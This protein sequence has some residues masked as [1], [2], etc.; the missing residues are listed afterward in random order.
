MNKPIGPSW[1]GIALLLCAALAHGQ[2]GSYDWSG[3]SVLGPGVKHATI[4][5]GR[6]RIDCVQIDTQT[7][8]L[9]FY[10]TERCP[11]YVADA[12]ETQTRK[13]VQFVSDSQRAPHPVLV[14]INA[15]EFSPVIVGKVNLLG[16]AAWEGT[17]VSAQG[18]P[19]LVI[20]KDGTARIT[21]LAAGADASQ[22]QAAVSGQQD[23]L[24]KGKPASGNRPNRRTAIGL[25]E[26]GRY[27][28][29]MTHTSAGIAEVGEWLRHCGAFDGVLMDGGRSTAMARWNGRSAVVVSGSWQ[30]SVGNSI[31]VYYDTPPADLAQG[32]NT[33]R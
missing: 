14:A 27:V 24:T 7:S 5:A 11:D 3:A 15:N 30:R 10:T 9:R 6:N 32:Y 18:G 20:G 16:Y 19:A 8:G 33:E 22:I 25:S 21:R 28:Y 31:G 13:T 12:Q 23:V 29:F 17:R 4:T 26:D 2:S 1:V